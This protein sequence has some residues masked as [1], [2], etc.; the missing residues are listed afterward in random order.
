MHPDSRL[1]SLVVE[2]VGSAAICGLAYAAEW[3]IDARRRGRRL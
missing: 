3:L 1:T 2:M